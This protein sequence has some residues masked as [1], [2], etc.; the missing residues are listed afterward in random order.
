MG[1]ETPIAASGQFLA[2]Q[3]TYHS[4]PLHAI[5]RKPSGDNYMPG[6]A[7]WAL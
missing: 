2:P 7:F 5:D 3:N 6:Q 4:T 1:Y